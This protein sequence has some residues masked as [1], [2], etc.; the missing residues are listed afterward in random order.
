MQPIG[1]VAF[2]SV[3]DTAVRKLV[4]QWEHAASGID[5]RTLF[6]NA[7]DDVAQVLADLVKDDARALAVAPLTLVI[8][9]G[10]AILNMTIS[11][12]PAEPVITAELWPARLPAIMVTMVER[13]ESPGKPDSPRAAHMDVHA[14]RCSSARSDMA[15]WVRPSSSRRRLTA[16]PRAAWNVGEADT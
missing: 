14:G 10:E 13:F 6:L 5:T 3:D 9:A 8:I 2:G 11:G 4:M 15:S 1:G 7:R 16:V 12:T